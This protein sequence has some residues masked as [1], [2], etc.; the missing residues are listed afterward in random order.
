[1][2]TETTSHARIN[3]AFLNPLTRRV[4]SRSAGKRIAVC[5]R[6]Y[7]VCAA[8]EESGN[9]FFMIAGYPDSRG[10]KEE[11]ASSNKQRA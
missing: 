8:S 3:I 10:A 9:A 4:A 11:Q 6:V 7:S 1:M 5:E 2:T